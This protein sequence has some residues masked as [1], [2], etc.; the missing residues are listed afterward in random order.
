M[1]EVC[2]LTE[3]RVHCIPCRELRVQLPAYH[4]VLSLP[5][6]GW[7]RSPFHSTLLHTFLPALAAHFTHSST[8]S[9]PAQA[10]CGLP[11]SRTPTPGTHQT[12]V[13]R[14]L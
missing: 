8:L 7:L 12:R 3:L 9:R 14:R 5:A 11:P 2:D 6:L 10:G 4:V 13:S 1:C